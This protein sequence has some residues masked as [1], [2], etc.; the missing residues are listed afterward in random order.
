MSKEIIVGKFGRA[1]GV[2][3][4][5]YVISYTDSPTNILDYQ[6][7]LIKN[8]GEWQ[9]ITIT[10]KKSHDHSIIVHIQ[11]WEDREIAKLHT[12]DEIA[13]PIENLPKL[14]SEEF[15]WNQLIGLEVVDQEGKSLGTVTGLL[16][17]GANDVLVVKGETEHLVPYTQNTIIKVDL[18]THQIIV[19]WEPLD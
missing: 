19:D 7:W 14:E 12:N 16:E 2:R 17:T 3:G 4:D 15:Y 11:G 9:P 5:I 13:V 8:K 1:H 18:D 6:P 10:S